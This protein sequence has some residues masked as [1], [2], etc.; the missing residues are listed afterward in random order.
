[1]NREYDILARLQ[2]AVGPDVRGIRIRVVGGIVL[3]AVGVQVGQV[4]RVS[5]VAPL[6]GEVD[7]AL[8][9]TTPHQLGT[10]ATQ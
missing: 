1:M 4:L 6:A 10:Q 7:V 5:P 3:V 8:A 2:G 9:S